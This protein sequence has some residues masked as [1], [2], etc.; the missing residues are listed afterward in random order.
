MSDF[1]KPDNSSQLE[2][3]PGDPAAKFALAEP[4]LRSLHNNRLVYRERF[5]A[6]VEVPNLVF[7]KQGIRGN[8]K[9]V[10]YLYMPHFLQAI[11]D[12]LKKEWHFGN[13]WDNSVLSWNEE[14]V[15]RIGAPYC[16]WM[17]W[18]ETKLVAAVEAFAEQGDMKS[19]LDLFKPHQF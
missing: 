11:Q 15:L 5:I 7:D 1:T 12:R 9:L 6:L 18:P 3:R 14:G 4:I 19:A 17:I 10:H 8:V 2:E 16:G 13:T